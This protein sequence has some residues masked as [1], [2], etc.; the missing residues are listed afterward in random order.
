MIILDTIRHKA[1]ELY[2]I[3]KLQF[4]VLK[5]L[6]LSS[7]SLSLSLS[8]ES[9]RI[10]NFPNLEISS[11]FD[12]L[13]IYGFWFHLKFQKKMPRGS[14]RK[15]AKEAGLKPKEDECVRVFVRVRPLSHK[16]KGNGNRKSCFCDANSDSKSAI[17][18]IRERIPRCLRLTE[19]FEQ[20]VTQEH[21]Y[22]VAASSIVEGV[23]EGYNGTI[24][25]YGQTG[26]GKRTRTCRFKHVFSRNTHTHTNRWRRAIP[27]HRNS[28]ESF[29]TRLH[30]FL[31][32]SRARVLFGSTSFLEIYNEE[33]RDLLSTK[34]RSSRACRFGCIRGGSDDARGKICGTD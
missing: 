3:S 30:I 15:L 16:E 22:N 29:Q 26:A 25:C 13:K 27:I 17:R 21:V 19:P 6:S 32:R 31:M 4:F 20:D 10:S 23:L 12:R 14:M 34:V 2:E 5:N 11:C 7:L 24:F 9:L 28:K 33:I 1:T 8:D 18:T